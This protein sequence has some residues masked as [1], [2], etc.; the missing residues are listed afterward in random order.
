M[1]RFESSVGSRPFHT[2]ARIVLIGGRFHFT[3][4]ATGRED[5][6]GCIKKHRLSVTQPQLIEKLKVK[7]EA[8]YP[9]TISAFE[10]GRREP[11]LSCC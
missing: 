9:T 2:A 10:K 11:P 3:N 5:P 7:N 6:A 8:V 4:V 1:S